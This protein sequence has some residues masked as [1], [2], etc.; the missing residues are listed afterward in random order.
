[1][2]WHAVSATSRNLQEHGC[3][4]CWPSRKKS[5]PVPASAQFGLS[6]RQSLAPSPDHLGLLKQFFLIAQPA[7]NCEVSSDQSCHVATWE[8]NGGADPSPTSMLTRGPCVGTSTR[9]LDADGSRECQPK[10]G[11]DTCGHECRSLR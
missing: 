5:Q 8:R 4:Q 7:H 3:Q 11:C 10:H 2:G 6:T 9:H 1:M